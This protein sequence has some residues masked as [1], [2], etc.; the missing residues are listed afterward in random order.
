MI[1]RLVLVLGLLSITTVSSAA[2]TET[3]KD[4]GPE[5]IQLKMGNMTLPFKH[6][7]HQKTVN[8]E[9]Y[10][11]H[12]TKIGRIDGWSKDTAH[13]ICIACHELEDRGPVTCLECHPKPKAN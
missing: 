12:N 10:H 8:N 11:C 6:W 3:P 5:V 2:V 13:K 7:K 1:K 4:K 9:C